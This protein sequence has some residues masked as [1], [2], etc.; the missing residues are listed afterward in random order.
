MKNTF[1]EESKIKELSVLSAHPARGWG[2]S[3]R[4]EDNPHLC[5][6][7]ENRKETALSWHL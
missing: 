4:S 3:G 6:L 2:M 5:L 1:L 7:V